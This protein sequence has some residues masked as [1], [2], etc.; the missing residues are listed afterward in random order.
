MEGCGSKGCEGSEGCD[1]S[2]GSEMGCA[3][4]SS[5]KEKE[6][7]LITVLRKGHDNVLVYRNNL[8]KCGPFRC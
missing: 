1:G 4:V 8:R 6:R 3:L 2:E 7:P 5:E